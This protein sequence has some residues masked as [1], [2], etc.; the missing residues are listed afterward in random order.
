MNEFT[1]AVLYGQ[2]QKLDLI[3]SSVWRQNA[4]KVRTAIAGVPNLKLRKSPDLEGDLGVG[5][6]LDL[7][8][9]Q[10]RDKFIA[11]MDAEGVPASPPG[12]S[13]IL[14]IN[15]RIEEQ[16]YRPSRLAFLSESAR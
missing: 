1:G 9:N 4:R 13:V 14:P 15:A 3:C 2:L 6:F 12:G 10:R 11:A 8:T 16:S 7:G 5:V